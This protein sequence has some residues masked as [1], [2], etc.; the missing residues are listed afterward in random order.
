MK[1]TEWTDNEL[2][3]IKKNYNILSYKEIAQT[4]DRS[5]NAVALKIN[6]LGLKRDLMQYNRNYFENITTEDQAYWLGFIYADGWVTLDKEN[7]GCL[8][9]ELQIQDIEHLR[10]FNKC[11]EGNVEVKTRM[12][13]VSYI[14]GRQIPSRPMCQIRLF[15][16]KI[17]HDLHQY[18]VYPKKTYDMTFPEN[19]SPQLI[20]HFVRGY[21]DGDGCINKQNH[22]NG[23]QYIRCDFSCHSLDF[24]TQLRT[25]LFQHDINSYICQDKKNYRLYIGGLENVDRY[26]NFIYNDATIFLDRKFNKT[27][28]LYKELHIAQR[29]P[30]K[31]EMTC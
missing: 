27:V 4:L 23:Q 31:S 15:S 13:N 24:L 3:F 8:G 28:T 30:R 9:I 2:D 11:I 5:Y 20:Q 6:R 19:L 1:N 18:G 26:L 10:K 16:E 21:F 14:D 29:L 25:I 12:S 22:K 17:V 7:R